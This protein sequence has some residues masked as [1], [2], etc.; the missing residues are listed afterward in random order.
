MSS[1]SYPVFCL[2][3][4]FL[5]F[6]ETDN[7]AKRKKHRSRNSE[8]TH[9]MHAAQIYAEM[10]GQVRHK[11]LYGPNPNGYQEVESLPNLS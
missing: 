9:Q 8:T 10:L 7:Q 5:F 4:T 2:K 3:V 11:K 1:C 6:L